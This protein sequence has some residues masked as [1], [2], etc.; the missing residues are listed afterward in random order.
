MQDEWLVYSTGFS[1]LFNE[2]ETNCGNI[3]DSTTLTFDGLGSIKLVIGDCDQENVYLFAHHIWKSSVLLAKL[4][5]IDKALVREK[6]CLEFGAGAGLPSI[7]ANLVGANHITASDY[8]DKGIIDKL[9]L[10][11]ETNC[12]AGS[13]S[14]VGHAWG[15]RDT[16]LFQ[17]PIR[18]YDTIIMADTLWLSDQ[19]INLWSDLV[20]LL[21][22]RGKLVIIAG[23]HSGLNILNSFLEMAPSSYSTIVKQYYEIPIGN[24]F[25]ENAHWKIVDQ[26]V[27][28][29]KLE[30]NRY[31]LH[32]Q[33]VSN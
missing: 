17:E 10:N 13:Y 18:Q 3:G 26:H 15:S 23:L 1:A 31:L 16:S 6:D 29:S 4:I 25:H 2:P 30:R 12:S 32:V 14:V 11:L 9:R 19:H 20:L 22:P 5:I 33:L 24:E 28:D 8:P 21:K 27:N 7:V